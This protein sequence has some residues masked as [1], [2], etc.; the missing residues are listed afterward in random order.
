[1][2]KARAA[3][4]HPSTRDAF[5]DLEAQEVERRNRFQ[6]EIAR[7]RRRLRIF[8]SNALAAGVAGLQLAPENA[9]FSARLAIGARLAAELPVHAGVAP[10]WGWLNGVALGHQALGALDDP[11]EDL[12]CDEIGFTDG[13]YLALPSNFADDFFATKHLLRAIFGGDKAL[14]PTA[15]DGELFLLTRC[16]LRLSDVMLRRAGLSRGIGD[17][18]H[19]RRDVHVPNRVRL[20]RLSDAV[21]FTDRDLAELVDP[22]AHRHLAPLVHPPAMVLS[23]EELTHNGLAARPLRELNDGLIVAIPRHLL[24]ALRHRVL[25]RVSSSRSRKAVAFALH[26]AIGQEVTAA[27]ARM[28][29]LPTDAEAAHET[30]GALVSRRVFA[31]DTKKDANVAVVTD[32]LKGY[33]ENDVNP[34]WPVGPLFAR[35]DRARR[36]Y[37]RATGRDVLSLTLVQSSGRYARTSEMFGADR[38][39]RWLTMSVDEFRVIALLE[40]PDRLA[41]WKFV[42]AC[43][44]LADAMKLRMWDVLGLYHAHQ[45]T[46]GGLAALISRAADR[47]EGVVFYP[48]AGSTLKFRIS[49]LIDPHLERYPDPALLVDV[50]R[51]YREAQSPLYVPMFG[52]RPSRVVRAFG[53][54]LWIEGPDTLEPETDA[55]DTHE[56]LCEVIAHWL[57]QVA[58]AN[59]DPL[60][61]EPQLIQV[62]VDDQLDWQSGTEVSASEPIASAE[63]TATGVRLRLLRGMGARCSGPNNAGEREIMVVLL[64]TLLRS[65]PDQLAALP[66]TINAVMPLGQ[67]RR[68]PSR[69]QR[70]MLHERGLPPMRGVQRVDEHAL[71]VALGA[72]LLDDIGLRPGVVDDADRIRVINEATTW[73]FQRMERRV[74]QLHPAGLLEGL[75]VSHERLIYEDYVSQNGVETEVRCWSS[76]AEVEAR[77]R[78]SVPRF[79]ALLTAS[80]FLIEYVAARPPSGDEAVSLSAYDELLAIASTIFDLGTT[81]DTIYYG[82]VDQSLAL[83]ADGLMWFGA[84]PID[85]ERTRNARS[86]VARDSVQRAELRDPTRSDTTGVSWETDYAPIWERVNVAFEQAEGFRV[87]DVPL[88]LN[89][90]IKATEDD[91][92]EVSTLSTAAARSVISSALGWSADRADAAIDLLSLKQRAAFLAPAPLATKDDVLPW[93]YGRRLS[94]ARRPLVLRGDEILFGWRQLVASKLH[95][96]YLC[97]SGRLRRAPGSDLDHTLTQMR[98]LDARAFNNYVGARF[99]GARFRVDL[100]VDRIDGMPLQR[101]NAERIGDV[102]VLVADCDYRLIYG[103]DTKDHAQGRNAREIANE[104][105]ALFVD[106]PGKRS[107]VTAHL[108]RDRWLR[109]H[110]PAVLRHLRLDPAESSQ[111]RVASLLVFDEVLA[112]STRRSPIELITI[113]ELETRLVRGGPLIKATNRARRQ[114]PPGWVR[115]ATVVGQRH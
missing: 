86:A 22:D 37:A 47:P 7:L 44:A 31:F 52:S 75:M 104:V 41:V 69:D 19:G 8:D 15:L 95:L 71:R 82:V 91:L 36:T 5:S 39:H 61:R 99:D 78:E 109:A 58:R 96:F 85:A 59:T 115:G 80:R 54:A 103:I 92:S 1:L 112:S 6:E 35:L 45:R 98:Q 28:G 79:A 89:A 51:G 20:S 70:P 27:A 114:A 12:F 66:R 49:E 108:E 88:V 110:V 16:V 13:P 18:V 94:Y 46:T 100:R 10:E 63:P 24:T 3:L 11:L 56:A 81:S 111:W 33:P 106:R 93:K 107:M 17:E 34:S 102:D 14:L 42:E 87:D 97:R 65:E 90:L 77:L 53:V 105:T 38:N 72:H 30:S 60:L 43:R 29:W 2:I 48:G 68:I 113:A 9:P 84:S 73:C 64:T 57:C 62:V 67:K 55:F 4:E 83:D 26:D 32:A 74:A 76:A 21:R 23:D 40:A 101:A 50:G 25:F